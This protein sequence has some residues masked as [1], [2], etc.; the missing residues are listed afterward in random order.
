MT[1]L[2]RPIAGAAILTLGLAAHAEVAG[3]WAI[4]WEGFRGTNRNVLTL[5]ETDDGYQ[6]HIAGPRG[7]RTIDA[8]AVDG[9]TFSFDLSMRTRMGMIDL[10]YSGT[11][12]G[13]SVSGTVATPMGE[14]PFT[15]ERKE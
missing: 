6:A 13:D 8:V 11:V 14:R 7:E 12:A 1:S 5:E 3:K 4:T 9:D 2:F 10:T 15:G